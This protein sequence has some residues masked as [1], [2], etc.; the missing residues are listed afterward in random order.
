M[1]DKLD[2]NEIE[3]L[4]PKWIQG[5][6]DI[7]NLGY[8]FTSKFDIATIYGPNFKSFGMRDL[9][10]SLLNSLK[11]MQKEEIIQNSYDKCEKFVSWEE[12]SNLDAD[13]YR[14]F[15]LVDDVKWINA[16]RG[17]QNLY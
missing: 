1:L 12:K 9:H 14:G 13:P 8:V 10:T 4:P 2:F 11:L 7:T 17:R 3:K 5:Y 16:K 15:E 6:S